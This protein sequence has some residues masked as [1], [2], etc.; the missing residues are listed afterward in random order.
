MYCMHII[1]GLC[2]DFVHIVFACV[3]CMYVHNHK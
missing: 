3:D 1:C 2:V